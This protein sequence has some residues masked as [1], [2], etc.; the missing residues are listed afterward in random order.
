MRSLLRRTLSVLVV[1]AVTSA[2]VFAAVTVIAQASPR[3]QLAATA[4]V[5]PATGCAATSCHA[6]GT[7]RTLLDDSAQPH[8]TSQATYRCPRTG[9]TA[10]TCHAAGGTF[11]H[12]YGYGAPPE[13]A[14]RPRTF[15]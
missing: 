7:S 10:S 4:L 12:G 5:C 11:H 3:S 15:Y 8:G 6:E 1:T 2:S 9:C 14:P 13:Q